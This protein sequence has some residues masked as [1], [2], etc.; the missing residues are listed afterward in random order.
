STTYV[1]STTTPSYRRY[2][3]GV[4]SNTTNSKV[5][6]LATGC[7]KQAD[8][9]YRC[10]DRLTRL[11]DGMFSFLE[12]NNPIFNNVSVGLGHFSTYSSGTTG[13]GSN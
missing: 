4:S 7:E 12:N 9:S 1:N 3:C 6:N 10:Y 8:N 13:D 5:T 2:Y 11:K